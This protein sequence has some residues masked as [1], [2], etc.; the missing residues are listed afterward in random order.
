STAKLGEYER[1][2][3]FGKTAE[4]AP[5]RGGRRKGG[6]RFRVQEHSATRPHR[7]LRVEHAGVGVSWAAPNGIPHDPAENRK[8]VHTEDHPLEYFSFEGTIPKG[9]YAAGSR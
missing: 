9:E 1:K 8:A 3:D 6:P 4:P 7:D 5:R 2:R